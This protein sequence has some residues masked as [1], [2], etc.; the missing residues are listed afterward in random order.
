M[1][2]FRQR[3]DARSART[4]LPVEVHRY[5]GGILNPLDCQALI[6]GG[7]EDHVHFL[8]RLSRTSSLADLMGLKG[9]TTAASLSGLN[10]LLGLYPG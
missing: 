10:P 3:S 5:L 7:V 4:R 9:W 6:V 1:A 2:S 8:T